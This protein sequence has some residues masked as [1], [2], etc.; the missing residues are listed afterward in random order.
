MKL[1]VVLASLHQG[2]L[3]GWLLHCSTCST[4]PLGGKGG[5]VEQVKPV[6]PHHLLAPRG[7]TWSGRWSSF[8]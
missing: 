7:G 3:E 2:V 8:G 1:K 5:G 4:P 6:E